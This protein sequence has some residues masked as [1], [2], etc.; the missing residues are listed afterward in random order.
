MSLIDVAYGLRH[1]NFLSCSI[2][3]VKKCRNDA[4]WIAFAVA[5]HLEMSLEKKLQ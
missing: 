2:D 1:P 5:Y 3:L 4:P